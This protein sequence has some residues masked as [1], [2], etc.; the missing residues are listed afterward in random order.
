MA[1]IFYYKP[2]SENRIPT[3]AK[4]MALRSGFLQCGLKDLGR[5]NIRGGIRVGGICVH[6]CR[7]DGFQKIKVGSMFFRPLFA[8]YVYAFISRMNRF[9][10]YGQR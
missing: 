1:C 3:G 9:R 10:L 5:E 8:L 7:I 6:D 4:K 2:C